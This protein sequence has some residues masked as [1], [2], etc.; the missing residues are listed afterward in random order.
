MDRGEM[1]TLVRRRMTPEQ[2]EMLTDPEINS[3]INQGIVELSKELGGEMT[4]GSLNFATLAD[5]TVALPDD[6]LRIERVDNDGVRVAR[7][8]M[9]EI[10]D[11][12]D[13]T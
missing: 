2:N 4:T 10:P 12:N 7:I 6:C 11:L 8:N 9:D 3:M 5:G 13:T 1:R